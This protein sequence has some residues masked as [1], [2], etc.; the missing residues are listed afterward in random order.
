MAFAIKAEIRDARAT[1]K[2]E[3]LERPP[4]IFKQAPRPKA[5]ASPSET[6]ESVSF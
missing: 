2:G 4:F 1:K 6:T 5:E 3:R